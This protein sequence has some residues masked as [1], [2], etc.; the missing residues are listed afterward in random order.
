MVKGRFLGTLII[1]AALGAALAAAGCHHGVEG[2]YTNSTNTI[3]IEFRG[4]KAFAS[5]SGVAD[6]DGTP[7]D[8]SGNKITIHYGK[9]NLLGETVLTINSDGTL[10]G[11]MGILHKK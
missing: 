2:V 6:P 8:I 4:N 10:Q 3:T 9:E 5:I 1:A 11:P 7:F